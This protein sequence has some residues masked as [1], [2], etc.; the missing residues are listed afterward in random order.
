M[1]LLVVLAGPCLALSVGPSGR[2]SLPFFVFVFA[3]ALLPFEIHHFLG[4]FRSS[5]RVRG[6]CICGSSDVV[7]VVGDGP[8]VFVFAFAWGVPS[9]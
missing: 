1:V 6:P 3:F 4:R 2:F 5:G 8:V 9:D 7:V